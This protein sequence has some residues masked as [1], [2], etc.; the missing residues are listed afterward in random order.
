M[1]TG[2]TLP[3]NF[4]VDIPQTG[5]VRSR[6]VQQ[7]Q[8]H[9]V[10]TVQPPDAV[11][12]VASDEAEPMSVDQHVGREEGE[13]LEG[14]KWVL[15]VDGTDSERENFN[16]G[17]VHATQTQESAPPQSV[18]WHCRS[19]LKNPCD[20]PTATMCGHIFCYRC[21]VR[22]ISDKMQCPVCNRLFL[23]RLHATA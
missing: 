18:S 15:P 23:L 9:V 22:E 12:T 20:E 4:P 21:I 5:D 1:K 17:D 3:A 7:L 2:E 13:A 11:E 8:Q 14:G 10:V 16:S 6:A 19:C